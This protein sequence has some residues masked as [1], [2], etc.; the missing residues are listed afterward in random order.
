MNRN[1][2][3]VL[4]LLA[5]LSMVNAIPHQFYKRTSNFGPCPKAPPEATVLDV[6]LSP[7]P[8]IAGK[9]DTFTITGKFKGEV[10]TKTKVVVDFFASQAEP[11]IDDACKYTTCPVPPGTEIIA[12]VEGKLEACIYNPDPDPGPGRQT[13][14]VQ[15]R[16]YRNSGQIIIFGRN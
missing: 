6:K 1:F 14:F 13:I 9:T 12:K 16:I 15:T 8:V 10:T 11:F 3:F 4:V 5:T 2:I 7:D